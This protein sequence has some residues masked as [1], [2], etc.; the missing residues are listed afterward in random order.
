MNDARPP[1]HPTRPRLVLRVG[2]VGHRWNRL[3]L[4]VEQRAG[5]GPLEATLGDERALLASCDHVLRRIASTV[6]AVAEQ[7]VGYQ[8]RTARLALVSGLAEGADRIAAHAAL[9]QGYEL[10]AV[11]PFDPAA[12]LADFDEAW[13]PPMW[14]RPGAQNEFGALLSRASDSIVMDGSPGDPE[15]YVALGRTVLHHSDLIIGIWNR[16]A[17]AGAG[18]TDHLLRAARQSE[19]PIIRVD[20]AD[21]ERAWLEDPREPDDGV[22][23]ELSLLDRRIRALIEAPPGPD[24]REDFFQETF[25]RGHLGKAYGVMS[26]LVRDLGPVGRRLTPT[27][28]GWLQVLA[29]IVRPTWREHWVPATRARWE[30]EWSTDSPVDA[31]LRARLIES[32][33]TPYAWADNLATFYANRYRS[34]F[35]LVFS[36]A[37]VAAAVGVIGFVAHVRE[38]HLISNLTASL[39]VAVVGT[40]TGLAW[41]GRRQQYHEKWIDYRTLAERLRHLTVLWPTGASVPFGRMAEHVPVSEAEAEDAPVRGPDDPRV[42][43]VGWFYR[44][45]V[46]ELGFAT[47]EFNPVHVESCR[48]LL[49]NHE[50]G[51]QLAFH[52]KAMGRLER[53]HRNIEG[54]AKF[55]FKLALLV[56]VLHVVLFEPIG[57]LIGFHPSLT[58]LLWIAAGLTLLSVFLPARAA[59]L[60]GW[61]GHADFY[62]A[63]LRSAQIATRLRELERVIQTV[64]P[65]DSGT[66]GEFAVEATRVMESELLAWQTVSRSKPLTD[67]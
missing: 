14:S 4:P 57:P 58:A 28:F 65:L 48:R 52:T 60:N 36:L 22:S 15:A 53:I 23:A 1:E 46:R 30:D 62:G 40:I 44:A 8:D 37:W 16:E 11:L 6:N 10:W 7:G 9:A 27:A 43:W 20:P 21:P 32:L 66:I 31:D 35:T 5:V 49:V 56:A 47:G 39:E 51:D 18:G 25:V 29:R 26:T 24:L 19:I 2:I 59:A 17:A 41:W 3:G 55:L 64:S 38:N 61:A 45:T 67:A 33:A 34:A 50:I 12:Y 54:R 42:T 13:R 63:A